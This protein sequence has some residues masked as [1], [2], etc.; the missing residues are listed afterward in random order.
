M[1]IAGSNPIAALAMGA[2]GPG[3]T[4]NAPNGAAP[5][6]T[7][8]NVDS[9]TVKD[10]AAANT[11]AQKASDP[12]F[13]AADEL[14]GLVNLFYENLGGDAGTID[15]KKFENPSDTTTNTTSG[16]AYLQATF[17]GRKGQ[18]DVTG[19]DDNKKLLKAIDDLVAVSCK[20]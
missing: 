4:V 10:V 19:T 6:G 14:R 15:W 1:V 5:N 20:A 7:T 18:I 8:T 17:K 11:A 16:C 2:A 3:K 13:V 12:A 9:T